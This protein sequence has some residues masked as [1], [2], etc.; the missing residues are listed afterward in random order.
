M[1]RTSLP[2]YMARLLHR[3]FSMRT[4]N[5]QERPTGSIE[6]EICGSPQSTTI[7]R[8]TDNMPCR[9]SRM[10]PPV[11]AA[12]EANRTVDTMAGL[13]AILVHCALFRVSSLCFCLSSAL[14]LGR[15]VVPV[16]WSTP[17]VAAMLG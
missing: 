8:S 15:R 10:F 17:T 16:Q 9:S 3:V 12:F 14:K 2:K 6:Q 7:D 5:L 11:L 4:P 1:R 13:R